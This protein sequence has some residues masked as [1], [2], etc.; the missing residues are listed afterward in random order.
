MGTTVP[1]HEFATGL[2]SVGTLT[3]AQGTYVYMAPEMYRGDTN[4]TNKV[5]VFSFGMTLWELCTCKTPWGDEMRD[6]SETEGYEFLRNALLTGKRPTI[7]EETRRDQPDLLTVLT[8]CWADDPADRPSFQQVTDLLAP[9]LRK[10]C[11][12][13]IYE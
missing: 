5:D 10:Q 4:Y 3:R 7:P 6:T 9:I 13:R 11:S 2:E 8:R 1:F 12:D